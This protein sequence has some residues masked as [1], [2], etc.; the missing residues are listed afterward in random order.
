MKAAMSDHKQVLHSQP[1]SPQSQKCAVSLMSPRDTT[2][3]NKM[4]TKGPEVPSLP[5]QD[6]PLSAFTPSRA[7]SPSSS[8]RDSSQP[9]S[10]PFRSRPLHFSPCSPGGA[11]RSASPRVHSPASSQIFERD[12]QEDIVPAQVS[13]SIPS[14]IITE[15]H[16]PPILEASSVALTD[17]RLNPDLVEIVTHNSH[18]TASLPTTSGNVPNGFSLG[19]P[20]DDASTHNFPGHDYKPSAGHADNGDIRRLSF[21]SFADL[22]N[23]EHMGNE[24]LSNHDSVY[25]GGVPASPFLVHSR[26]YSPEN[27]YGSPQNFSIS[28]PRSSSLSV[29]AIDTFPSNRD[30]GSVSPHLSTRSRPITLSPEFNIE[31]MTQALKRT[32]SSEFGGLLS[33]PMSV[34]GSDDGEHA[35]SPIQ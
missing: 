25:H 12:V 13:P 35:R 16:I 6:K 14:H 3:S 8:A 1:P 24:L 7:P 17:E 26:P 4:N 20:Y 28:P 15:N 21:V 11:L 33:Q 27:G 30:T 5:V 31:T 32:E 2:S 10:S 23:G 34:V 29:N 19:S 22:V 18:Q 9:P